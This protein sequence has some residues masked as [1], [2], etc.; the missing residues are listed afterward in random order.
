MIQV[1][2]DYLPKVGLKPI[3]KKIVSRAGLYV[4]ESNIKVAGNLSRTRK[5]CIEKY[6]Y[7][8]QLH[9]YPRL[10]GSVPMNYTWI[11]SVVEID[12]VTGEIFY[13]DDRSDTAYKNKLQSPYFS[14][15]LQQLEKINNGERVDP[16]TDD[17]RRIWK[18]Y[19]RCL[20]G[21]QRLFK[22][23]D[24][25]CYDCDGSGYAITGLQNDDGDEVVETCY[26]CGGDGYVDAGSK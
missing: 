23:E 19:L 24:N 25:Y 3:L 22:Q 20:Q 14:N 2:S 6:M 7:P 1:I 12:D 26:E 16:F 4:Y 8:A 18:R 9:Y 15:I 21:G 5:Y 13:L 10:C 17:Y 11:L